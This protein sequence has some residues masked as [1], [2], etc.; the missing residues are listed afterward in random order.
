MVRFFLE[1]INIL[2]P[3]F[4]FIQTAVPFCYS[5]KNI[6]IRKR[7]KHQI[8]ADKALVLVNCMHKH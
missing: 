8:V 6:I 2:V 3:F 7:S 4:P 5:V 1:T